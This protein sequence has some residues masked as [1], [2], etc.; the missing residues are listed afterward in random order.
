MKTRTRILLSFLTLAGLLLGACGPLP[1]TS[2]PEPTATPAPVSAPTE[3][4]GVPST[5]LRASPPPPAETPTALP[6][7]AA[8]VSAKPVFAPFEEPAVEVVP[9]V[10]HEPIAPDLSNVRVSLALS[11]AQRERLARD[12]FVVSPGVEKEFFTVYEKARYANVPIFVSSDSLLHVYHLL[13]DKVLRTAEVQYFIPLLRDLNQAL[14]AQTDSQ[15]QALQGSGWE[16]AARRT[17][18]FVGV[19]SR[20][21]D[22]DVQVP[23]YAADL[24][25]AELALVEGAAGIL[26]SPLFPGL[27]YGE[28]Y[29]Q[30]IPRGHYTKSD[31]LKAYFKSM[32]WYGRM[33][34]RLKTDKPEVGRAETRSALLL[35]HALRTA[36]VAN[37]PALEAWADLYNPTVFF[38]GRSDD[39]TVLQ[40]IEVIDAIYGQGVTLTVLA[41]DALLDTF[42]EAANKLPPPRILGM[43]IMDT[44]EVEETTK[45]LRF[46]GQ[47]FV[48]DAYIFR[49]L[50]YRNVGTPDHRRGLPKGLDLLAAMGSQRAHQILDE[51]G[52]TAYENYPQQMAKVQKWVS[53]LSV[54]EWT[55]TLYNS[56]LYCFHPLLEVPGEGY[57]AFMQSP[58]WVD[59]QLHT[60]LGSWAELKHDTILYA[61][62]AYAE[63]GAGPMPPEPVPPRGYV[64]PVP[65]FYARLAALTA[66][67]RQG[68]GDRGLLVEQDDYSLQ[69]LEELARAFQ[70]MAEKE[71]QGEPLTEEEYSIIRFYG[72]DLEHLTMAAADT[73]EGEPG[74]RAYM[75]EE[76]QAAVIADVA[77]DPWPTPIVLEEAVGRV[78]EIHV[79]VPVVGED[80]TTYLQ[81]AKGG[82]FS[83]YEFPWPADDRLTDEKWRQML[84]QGQAPLPP[85]WISSFFTT[86]G[87]YSELTEAVFRFQ[88]SLS[89]AVWLLEAN[90]L[91]ARGAALEQLSAKIEALRAEKR[92]EGRQLLRS[93]FRSFDR[94]ARDQAVVTVRETWQDGL[95]EFSQ[96]PG[97]EGGEPLAQRGP[98]TLDVTYTL[99]RGES[100]WMVTRLVYANEPPAW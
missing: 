71:L 64:E 1:P 5:P 48:P 59:K 57:P 74:G 54:A 13:F 33:T 14:L 87:E 16:E 94:Q 97:Q 63:L 79:V 42:I 11:E 21:L 83:Y 76:P 58:A 45:G 25:E 34:F 70:T 77:T 29:T 72:G 20:L 81:V 37:Q 38:V 95:Y 43:V 68:L 89:G 31:E 17:V 3:T 84:D 55:E 82:V 24:V 44:D 62:Q 6:T 27:E 30:Y 26:P 49:Q 51:M 2:P 86:E 91:S 7:P 22:P 80:G 18:A 61:K 28:D 15:Y 39:L 41:D 10:H 85:E 65:H 75:E 73:P 47:R 66:M 35:V 96:Y 78:N 53:G 69:R 46:M 100:G 93:D 92:Y 88:K 99:E 19:A 90:Y 56:W 60:V 23:D 12:G 67:T 98:Y 4:P 52:E 50:M 8:L 36:E 40:Y 9:A 32:M